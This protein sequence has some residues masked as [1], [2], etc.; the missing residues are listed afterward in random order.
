MQQKNLPSQESLLPIRNRPVIV[1]LQEQLLVPAPVNQ[2]SMH[3]HKIY[4]W[5]CICCYGSSMH[6]YAEVHGSG[7]AC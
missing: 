5:L 3:T 6:T 4:A 2:A 7:I 1:E